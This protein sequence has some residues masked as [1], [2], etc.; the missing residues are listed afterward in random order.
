MNLQQSKDLGRSIDYMETRPDIDSHK[1]AFLGS[2]YGSAMAP[3]MVAFEP[4]IKCLVMVSG[5]SF[6]RAPAEVDSWNFAPRVRIPVLMVNGR[7]DFR[8]PVESS[9]IPLFKLF[10]TPENDKRHVLRDGGH[11]NTAGRPDIVKEIL[12]WLDR[13]LGPIQTQ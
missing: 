8:F 5:G 13:Y 10:G 4:R 3:H 6:E 9:Q 12:D 1:L 7:D 11:I 2:S